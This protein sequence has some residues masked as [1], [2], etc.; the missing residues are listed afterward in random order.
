MTAPHPDN[1]PGR[2]AQPPPEARVIP[3]GPFIAGGADA[4]AKGPRSAGAAQPYVTIPAPSPAA[5]PDAAKPDAARPDAAPADA[6]RTPEKPDGAASAW[7]TGAPASASPA[8]PPKASP[9]R[10]PGGAARAVQAAGAGAIPATPVPTRQAEG[11][12]AVPGVAQRLARDVRPRARVLTLASGKGGVGKTS[13]AVNLA[14]G[15]AAHGKRV[16]LVDCDIGLANTDLLIGQRPRGDLGH[17]LAGRLPLEAIVQ[18]GPAG[19]RWIPGASYMPA[20]GSIDERQREALLDAL[21]ALE[22]QHDFVL[23]DAPAGIGS[24]VLALARQADELVLVTTP[25]PTAIMDAYVT[26]KAAAAPGA[27]AIGQV[28]LIVNLAAH[29]RDADR[30]HRRIDEV[31]RRFLGIPVGLLGY[32]FC[33]GHVG[34]AVLR[35]EPLLLAY[36]HSQAAWCVK[37]LAGAILEQSGPV[38]AARPGFF[39]RVANFF[40]RSADNADC[41]PSPRSRP[42]GPRSGE[43]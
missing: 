26:L 16:L 10:A 23:L 3:I 33:D 28:R 40:R 42:G 24:G 13:L 6:A 41:G 27:D 38:L 36:P 17:V 1:T 43:A 21:S 7:P 9:A 39:R 34:R 19:I 12:A 2:P 37:R 20:I 35:Q 5:R 15:L 31:A 11:R 25:E 4:P 29:R 18:E 8:A 30:V 22:S 14:I 32:V